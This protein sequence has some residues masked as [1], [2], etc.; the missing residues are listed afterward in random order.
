MVQKLRLDELLLRQNL[1]PTVEEA[2]AM[3]GA[4]EVY[5]NDQLLDK[6]GTPCTITSE[7]RVKERPRFVSRGGLKLEKGLQHFGIQVTNCT[8]LD[9]GASTGGFT[10]CLLQNGAK[11]IFAVDV[12]YGQLAWKIRQNSRVEVFERFNART[13]TSQHL[14]CEFIDIAVIDASFISL[15]KLLPPL[16]PLFKV[17]VT[18]IALIKPQFELLKSDIGKGGVVKENHLHQKAIDKIITFSTE[19]GLQSQGVVSSPILGPKGNKEFLIHL[20]SK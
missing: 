19:L 9:I 16:V 18:I 10:D 7:I 12:A 11:K 17:Q 6:P 1:A 4:G 15:T 20:S 5:V 2:Q 3:I 13:I 8:C 14:K